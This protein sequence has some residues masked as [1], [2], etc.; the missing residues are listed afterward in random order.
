MS[1]KAIEEIEQSIE[2]NKE[3]V[4]FGSSIERLR[5]NRDF[6]KV[7]V[8]G[9][10]NTEAVRLVKLLSDPALQRPEIQA[11]IVSDMRAI[12][13]LDSFLNHALADADKAKE[14]ISEAHTAIAGFNP[15]EHE[16]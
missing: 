7:I 12:G 14:A 5:S 3:K 1:N 2:V 4:E 6:K 16:E 9:Y 13:A 11:A 15:D 10:F 8:G